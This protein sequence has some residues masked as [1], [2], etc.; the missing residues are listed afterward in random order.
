MKSKRSEL[1]KNLNWITGLMLLA[2]SGAQAATLDRSNSVL[3]N[4]DNLVDHSD[5]TGSTSLIF[6][7]TN[8]EGVLFAMQGHSTFDHLEVVG[9]RMTNKTSPQV[10]IDTVRVT[11]TKKNGTF[12]APSVNSWESSITSVGSP[13][14]SK[15]D[16]SDPDFSVSVADTDT[17][18]VSAVLPLTIAIP[19]TEQFQFNLFLQPF[20]DPVS[21]WTLHV[22][23]N[24]AN[25]ISSVPLPAAFWLF[26]PVLLGWLGF[27]E[28]NRRNAAD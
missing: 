21:D 22:D 17:S 20:N 28:R 7:V 2:A 19:F 25:A 10:D 3:S 14:N 8:D 23:F 1:L 5:P 27:S 26:A 13:F 11:I 16:F 24:E 9:L 4:I 6:D 15:V 18:T 12:L